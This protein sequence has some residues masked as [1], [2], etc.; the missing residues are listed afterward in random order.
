MSTATLSFRECAEY[1][2]NLTAHNQILHINFTVSP[3]ELEEVDLGS[4]PSNYK[5]QEAIAGWVARERQKI[6]DNVANRLFL[7]SPI[8]GCLLVQETADAGT[9]F[10]EFRDPEIIRQMLDNSNPCRLWGLA[11]LTQLQALAAWFFKEK[12]TLLMTLMDPATFGRLELQDLL[13][14]APGRSK[15]EAHD[16]LHRVGIAISGD[17]QTV[18]RSI[19][20]A[21]SNQCLL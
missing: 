2:P 4:P 16:L 20:T 15:N 13:T 9:S 6:A 5:N 14:L 3:Q 1:R 12:Q 21:L 8:D 7:G 19:A 17:S 18:A 11:P 10:L